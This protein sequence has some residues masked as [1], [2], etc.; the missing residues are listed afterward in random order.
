[1][2]YAFIS[3]F[4]WVLGDFKLT[5]QQLLSNTMKNTFSSPTVNSLSGVYTDEIETISVMEGDS[6]ALNTGVTEIL[7]DDLILWTFK[8]YNSETRIAE[9]YKQI[10]SVYHSKENNEIFRDRLQIDEETGSL[11]ITN[12]NKLHSGLYKVQIISG[13]VKHKSFSVA[14]YALLT[15]PVISDFT[16]NPSVSERSSQQNCSLVCSVV[17]VGHVTLSWYKGH[18]LLSSIN[19]SDL[20]ISLFLPLEIE[21][22]DD[23]YSCVVAYSFNNQTKHL[24]INDLCQTCP[25]ASQH[26]FLT[27]LIIVA[28]LLLLL[29]V[30]I[31]GVVFKFCHCKNYKRTKQEAQTTEEEV[32]YTDATFATHS[33]MDME[34]NGEHQTEYSRVVLK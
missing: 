4:L 29:L 19:V 6:V 31:A 17:N 1:M 27:P 10:S 3:F 21:C 22:L 32:D 2:V 9:I 30:V 23:S 5:Q 14:V 12:I 33:A 7:T 20:S 15:V 18:S 28:V 13:D 34:T 24:N 25:G 16:Q 11:T 26:L 8:L